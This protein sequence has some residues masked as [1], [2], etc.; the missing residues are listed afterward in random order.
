MLSVES[1]GVRGAGGAI[2]LGA[3]AGAIVGGFLSARL[4]ARRTLR[5][6]SFK[7]SPSTMS[8]FKTSV[9]SISLMSY[10]RISLMAG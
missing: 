8:R 5:L 7:F 1:G 9:V 3:W 6:A 2:V 4:P 10:N